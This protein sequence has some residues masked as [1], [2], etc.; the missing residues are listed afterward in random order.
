VAGAARWPALVAAGAVGAALVARWPALALRPGG[1]AAALKTVINQRFARF[2][3]KTT[4]AVRFG[5]EKMTRP[6]YAFLKKKIK[7]LFF[8][9]KPPPEFAFFLGC[10]RKK[11]FLRLRFFPG[12]Q[13]RTRPAQL[14]GL[15][16]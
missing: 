12:S 4:L 16:L 7:A 2:S 9:E 8:L 14:A 5:G 10:S 3:Y 1:G 15:L 13:K 6:H 11:I